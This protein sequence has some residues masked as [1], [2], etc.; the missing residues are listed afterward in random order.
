MSVLA[1][2]LAAVAGLVGQSD[3]WAPVWADLETLRHGAPPAL[4][5]AAARA[6]LEQALV[7]AEDGPHADLLRAA[8]EAQD[9]REASALVQRLAAQRP[10]PFAGLACWILAELVPAGAERARLVR[11]ALQAPDALRRWQVLLAWNAALDEVRTLRLEDGALPIQIAL[12]ERFQDAAT[13]HDLAL[14][15]R[16]LGNGQAADRV[17]A[18]ALRRESEAGRRDASL[19]EARGINALGFG[20]E[21]LARDYLGRALAEGSQGAALL[22]SRLELAANRLAA[23]RAGFRALILDSPPPDWAWR[24]WGM[25][26]L[27]AAYAPARTRSPAPA[28]E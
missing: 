27:P 15:L 10:T 22:L 12:H 3:A 17:L 18:E 28:N 4:E 14:T 21:A 8:L 20:D 2:A 16:A 9:G 23:A 1:L 5:A 25:T 26:L 19:W 11:E 6:R 7:A 13:A 24:G